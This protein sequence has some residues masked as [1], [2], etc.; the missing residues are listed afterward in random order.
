M[1]GSKKDNG[2]LVRLD[3]KELRKLD[4]RVQ[5]ERQKHPGRVVTRAGLAREL[6]AR[7]L[8]ETG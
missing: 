7:G 2:I 1:S 6:I 5:K 4:E 8:E 3:D